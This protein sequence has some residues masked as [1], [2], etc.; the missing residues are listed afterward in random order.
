MWT[1]DEDFCAHCG[2]ILPIAT[3]AP[4]TINCINCQ[5][6]WKVGE[7]NKIINTREFS[8]EK[9]VQ[10]ADEGEGKGDEHGVQVDH[11]CSKCSHNKATYSTQ[12]TRSADEGQTV[13]YTCVK[14][15]NRDIEYS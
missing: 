12:Q 13:F 1:G 7:C 8:Y 10:E 4:V 5:V 3:R 9:T 6:E 15:G 2:Q 11:A 14:C